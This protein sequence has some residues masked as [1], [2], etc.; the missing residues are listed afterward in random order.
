MA[1]VV[2]SPSPTFKGYIATLHDV[3]ILIECCLLGMVKPITRRLQECEQDELIRSGN[4]FVF[5]EESSNIKRWTDGKRWGPSRTD[6]RFM[7]YQEK[8]LIPGSISKKSKTAKQNNRGISKPEFHGGGSVRS[9]VGY[10]DSRHPQL[11]K[12]CIAVTWRQSSSTASRY[13]LV[14]YYNLEDV[15]KLNTPSRHPSYQ[16]VHPRPGLS[17][18]TLN[19]ETHSAKRALDPTGNIPP[20]ASSAGSTYLSPY[21]PLSNEHRKGLP[22]PLYSR[23]LGDVPSNSKHDYLTVPRHHQLE[24]EYEIEEYIPGIRLHETHGGADMSEFPL[25]EGPDSTAGGE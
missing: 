10:D 9:L 24:S 6:E 21:I 22:L 20:R 1:Y 4:V 16:N 2:D 7:V 13:H 5:E 23:S 17:G 18:R 3:H 25:S 8:E 15:G 12:K 14:S 19:T 11:M